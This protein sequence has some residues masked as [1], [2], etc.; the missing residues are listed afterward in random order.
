MNVVRAWKDPRYRRQLSP[1]RDVLP[2]HPSGTVSMTDRE[3]DDIGGGSL[4]AGLGLGVAVTIG[5]C[6][7]NGTM[8]GSCKWGTLACC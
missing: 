3:L 5:L 6:S 4:L 8:C 7:P 2:T 1:D